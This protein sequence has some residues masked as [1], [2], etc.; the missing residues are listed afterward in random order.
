MISA[1]LSGVTMLSELALIIIISGLIQ[2]TVYQ[3]T[4]FSIFNNI[5]KALNNLDKKVNKYWEE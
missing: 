1:I 3:I 5:V 4:G 2:L